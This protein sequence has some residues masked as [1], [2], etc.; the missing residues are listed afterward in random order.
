MTRSIDAAGI[1]LA[2]TAAALYARGWMEGTAGNISIRLP[3]G[4]TALITASGV[5]K[6]SITAADVV[7][8]DIANARPVHDGAPRPSAET[9]IH[10]A[11]Y[12]LAD[13]SHA[14][15]HAHPPYATATAILAAQ[16]GVDTVTFTDLEIIKGLGL[17][18]PSKVVVPVFD[19][20]A[21]VPLIADDVLDRIA[22]DAPPVMLIGNHGATTWG[23]TLDIARNRME[24]LE[25]MC[26][27]MMLVAR[28]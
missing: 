25:A 13:D 22:A 17:S 8:V 20:H 21:H 11:L 6:G 2:E 16:R 24:C 28:S 1:A 18:D 23:P 15:V 14:V 7:E 9:T 10:T 3:G 26:Q 4:E 19:N 12:R 27:L 5:S